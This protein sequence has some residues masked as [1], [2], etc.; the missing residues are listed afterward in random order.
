M[1]KKFTDELFSKIVDEDNLYNAY[2]KSLNNNGKYN[3][4]AMVFALD[5][6]YNLMKLRQ[7]LI[8]ETYEFDGYIEF[9]VFEPKERIV[10][11]PFYKDKIVQLAINNVLKEIYNPCFIYDSYA[12]IDGK[13][14]H[15]CVDR[16][17]YFFRKSKW[18]YGEDAFIIKIDIKKFFYSIDRDVL[19]AT[20]SKKIRC[21]KTLRLLCKI[22]DSADAID[23]LGMPLGNTISQISANICMNEIDQYC[24]RRLNIKYY[25]RYMDDII[26]VVENKNKARKVF[27]NKTK[28]FPINQGVNAIG[29]K[30]YPTH[31]LLRNDSKKK[32]KRKIKA[33]PH[34]IKE[35]KLAVDKAEQMLNSWKGHA[36]H[37]NSF[38]FIQGLIAKFDF[39]YLVKKSNSTVIKIDTSKL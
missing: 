16:I 30:I 14:T 34:L 25:V 5:E 39:L 33:I 20:L 22:I 36:E 23:D 6:V 26:I 19:K 8:D 29:Y 32:I 31:K 4:D 17:Q 18:Q 12:C 10:N 2:K 37:A 3:P 28:I 15:K 11:A 27:Q 7:S 38:N 21:K 24:K 13:G 1:S 9:K 35:G